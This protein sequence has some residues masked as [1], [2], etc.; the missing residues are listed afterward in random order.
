LIEEITML[1]DG[2]FIKEEL[3]KIGKFYT[4]QIKEED[5]TPEEQFMQNL[6]L[7]YRDERHSFLSKVFGFILKV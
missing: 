5:R 1:R 4:P 6:L 2:Q 3:P 7:G